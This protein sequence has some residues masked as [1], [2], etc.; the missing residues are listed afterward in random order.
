MPLPSPFPLLLVF[1]ALYA[2][3]ILPAVWSRR[4][5]RRQAALRVLDRLLDALRSG[6]RP[7]GRRDRGRDLP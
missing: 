1:A 5:A 4:P 2:G 3:V 6:R 7:P